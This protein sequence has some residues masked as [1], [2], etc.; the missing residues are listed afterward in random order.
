MFNEDSNYNDFH[1]KGFYALLLLSSRPFKQDLYRG[2]STIIEAEKDMFIRFNRFISTSANLT[3]AM[4]YAT[5]R[6]TP[7]TLIVFK[8][9]KDATRIEN[10]NAIPHQDEYLI[11]PDTQ[12]RVSQVVDGPV[13]DTNPGRMIVLTRAFY[14]SALPSISSE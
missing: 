3:T 10:K 1:Y 4:M 5:R 9:I 8:G 2:A 11:E 6:A 13:S 7:G 14:P 12:F